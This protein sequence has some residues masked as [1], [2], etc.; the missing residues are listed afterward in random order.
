MKKKNQFVERNSCLWRL[1]IPPENI[2]RVVIERDQQHGNGLNENDYFLWEGFLIKAIWKI[3]RKKIWQ[4]CYMQNTTLYFKVVKLGVKL[5]T[6]KVT[7]KI[8]T[9]KKTGK[10]F[11]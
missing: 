9:Q 11:N 4:S 6:I 5:T 2:F 7:A 8:T 1:S 3:S 10:T